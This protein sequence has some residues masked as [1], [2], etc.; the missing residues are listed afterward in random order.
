MPKLINN[1]TNEVFVVAAAP[2][3]AG[4]VWECGDQR[5]MD[6]GKNIYTPF[7]EPNVS[8]V[9]F[10]LLWTSQERAAI[11]T[12][13]DTDPIV[14]DFYEIIDDPRLTLVNLS[15]TST[16]Q[17]VDYLLAKLVAADVLTEEQ[18]ADRREAI[19]SGVFL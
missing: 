19:L 3:W 9:E 15:L 12:L 6:V 8:P 10:K 4:G 16:Q 2:I 11:K 13:K 14:D 1:E 18:V 17:A 5:F 7:N